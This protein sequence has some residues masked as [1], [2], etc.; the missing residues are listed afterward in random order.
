MDN[1]NWDPEINPS[2]NDVAGSLVQDSSSDAISQMAKDL[3]VKLS[4]E[5]KDYLYQHYFQE[6]QNKSAWARTM[7]ADNTR[8]QR[9]VEDLKKAGLNPFL[10]ISSLSPSSQSSNSGQ[11]SGGSFTTQLTNKRTVTTEAGTKI[12]Q[13]IMT[14]L[15]VIAAA[16]IY[17]L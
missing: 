12:M 16:V 17:A 13:G 10:A 8:Y 14:M 2:S 1:L 6:Q 11:V 4:D 3:N 7:E 15:G 9:A 5:T